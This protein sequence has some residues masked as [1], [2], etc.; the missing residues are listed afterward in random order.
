M[1]N[2]KKTIIRLLL[3]LCG[4]VFYG[5]GVPELRLIN[6]EIRIELGTECN[7]SVGQLIDLTDYTEKQQ[8]EIIVDVSEVDVGKTGIYSGSVNY[9][10]QIKQFS[11]EV[12][13][14]TPPTV[15]WSKAEAYCLKGAKLKLSEFVLNISDNSDKVYAV[16]DD[17]SNVYS[18]DWDGIEFID[19]EFSFDVNGVYTKEVEIFDES[20]NKVCGSIV[21][22][23][24]SEPVINAE[25]KYLEVGDVEKFQRFINEIFVTDEI[26]GIIDEVKSIDISEVDLNSPGSYAVNIFYEN[27]KGISALKSVLYNVV[28]E[29]QIIADDVCLV[30][31]DTK[32][33]EKY[34]NSIYVEDEFDGIVTEEI[35]IR[36][37]G[38]IDKVG[39][40]AIVIEYENSK[41]ISA[42]KKVNVKII[43]RPVIRA[44]NVQIAINDNETLEAYWK[45]ISVTDDIDGIVVENIYIEKEKVNVLVTGEYIVGL[46]YINSKGIVATKNV[47]ITIYQPLS[48]EQMVEALKSKY[49]LNTVIPTE[50]YSLRDDGFISALELY[51]WCSDTRLGTPPDD[52]I[53]VRKMV[54]EYVYSHPELN[55]PY[56][57]TISWQPYE[58]LEGTHAAIIKVCVHRNYKD[59]WGI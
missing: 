12:I 47:T 2:M 52:D 14:T 34:I 11:V 36:E 24:I 17:A 15:E 50:V 7:I 8:E 33:Y 55:M 25:E 44:E 13:D 39:E 23:V 21:I 28:T 49:V 19:C 57:Y 43:N 22:H 59:S 32:G 26:D 54:N 4:T 30:V 27:T 31:G 41:G 40:H 48:Y 51:Y 53:D 35:L 42:S 20:G 1:E 38:D 9:G 5:C 3:A 45:S 16:V 10:E 56:G 37:E 46:K 6:E 18:M 58:Y 29:P